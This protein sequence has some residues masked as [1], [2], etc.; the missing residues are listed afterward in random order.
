MVLTPS[1]MLDLGTSEPDFILPDAGGNTIALAEFAGAP[2]TVIVFMCNHCP[3]VKH[4]ENE[5]AEF[6]REYQMREVV[7]IGANSNDAGTQPEDRPEAMIHGIVEFVGKSW[8][9]LVEFK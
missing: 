4:L 1:T 9:A 2:A 5:P 7:V 3:F 6:A 8:I